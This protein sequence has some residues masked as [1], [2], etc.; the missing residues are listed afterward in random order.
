MLHV[1]VR[2][3]VSLRPDES[4]QASANKCRLA[5]NEK[6]LFSKMNKIK[7]RFKTKLLRP[8]NRVKGDSWTFLL[9]PK[10]ASARLPS[11]G[12]TAVEGT[13]NGFAFQAVLEPDG[14]KGHWLK[15]ER[16]LSKAAGADTGDTVT[17]EIT[18]ASQDFEPKVPPDLR[19]A[20]SAAAPKARTVWSDITPVA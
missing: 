20:L 6:V 12:M 2:S 14:R 3:P 4:S 17:L 10:N 15:V 11:R 19:K 18:P 5:G 1:E 8:A 9:L 13:M 7:T 16:K